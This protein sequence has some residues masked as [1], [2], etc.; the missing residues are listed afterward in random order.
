[1]FRCRH[2]FYEARLN[3]IYVY[4]I[5]QCTIVFC[6]SRL[7]LS[8]YILC[9]ITSINLLVCDAFNV[10]FGKASSFLFL[11]QHSFI[12]IGFDVVTQENASKVNVQTLNNLS[13]IFPQAKIK[14]KH[15]KYNGLR[16]EKIIL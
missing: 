4:A 16:L 8:G 2:A 1:M 13:I 10:F 7:F 5:Q 3:F 14:T 12:V 11:V 6:V 15:L 9:C